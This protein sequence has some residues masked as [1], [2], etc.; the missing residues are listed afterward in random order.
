MQHPLGGSIALSRELGSSP[1]T[2]PRDLP[3]QA[4]A[5]GLTKRSEL[6][7]LGE[8]G[9]GEVAKFARDDA[10]GGYVLGMLWTL[11]RGWVGLAD[12]K[13]ICRGE[14]EGMWDVAVCT[15]T[16]ALLVPPILW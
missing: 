6:R 2:L 12:R 8:P 14:L 13:G 9:M 3:G 1:R 4:F 10:T 15:L 5:R 7:I 11:L 16:N